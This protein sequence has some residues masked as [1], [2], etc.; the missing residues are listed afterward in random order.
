MLSHDPLT[1]DAHMTFDVET[2][3]RLA[4]LEAEMKAQFAAVEQIRDD[5]K[6]RA[7]KQDRHAREIS[8]KLQ[9]LTDA[10]LKQQGFIKG[11]RFAVGVFW[12]LTG[13][14]VVAGFNYFFG[15]LVP[16]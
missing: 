15:G 14:V 7:D 1:R 13:G 10:A 6:A 12:A 3:A 9:A 5:G 8:D 16:R 2:A 11:F 4:T